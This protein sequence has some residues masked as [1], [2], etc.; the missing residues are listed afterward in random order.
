M[1]PYNDL[2]LDDQYKLR[3]TS[4]KLKSGNYQVK[5]FASVKRRRELYGYLLVG[6][7]ETLKNVISKIRS[8]LH[9]LDIQEDKR[10]FDVYNLRNE[11]VHEPNFMIFQ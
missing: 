2:I 5:F 7:D 8:R 6:A 11:A 10:Y 3:I 4:K 9:S 1:S